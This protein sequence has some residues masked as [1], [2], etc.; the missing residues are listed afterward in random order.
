MC[1]LD[2]HSNKPIL[3]KSLLRI[4]KDLHLFRFLIKLFQKMDLLM[5]KKYIIIEGFN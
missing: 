2:T 5:G 1:A 4:E 3:K